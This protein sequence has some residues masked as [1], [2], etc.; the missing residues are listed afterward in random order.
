MDDYLSKPVQLEDLAEMLHKY[1]PARRSK[2]KDRQK[3]GKS[4]DKF[5][6]NIKWKANP[7]K[8]PIK[9]VQAIPAKIIAAQLILETITVGNRYAFAS[10]TA[11]STNNVKIVTNQAGNS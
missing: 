7:A 9:Y 6:L 2:K 11:T 3:D 1:V 5:L 10:G 4:T 8:S